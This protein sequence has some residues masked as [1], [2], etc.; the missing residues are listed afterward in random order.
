MLVSSESEDSSGL[1]GCKFVPVKTNQAGIRSQL[2]RLRIY[3]EST[4]HH[5]KVRPPGRVLDRR[6]SLRGVC[7]C[8]C[9][10]VERSEHY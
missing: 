2:L 5:L 3:S 9:A 8:L 6:K 1:P 7:G 10:A 4:S